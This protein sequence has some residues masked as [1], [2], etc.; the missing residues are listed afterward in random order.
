MPTRRRKSSP[1]L[2]ISAT[3]I[4]DASERLIAE[5]ST[6]NHTFEVDID[7]IAPDPA[8]A[9]RSF[10]E[11]SLAAL[12]TTLEAEGQLQ[13]VLLRRDPDNRAG[14]IIVAGE[15]RWR[16]AKLLN[17]PKL[18]AMAYTGDAEVAALVENLQRV[19]LSPVEEA[20]GIAR[21]IAEKGW[22]QDRAAQ[23][24]GKPKSDVSGTLR[25]L[26]L[27]PE[28]LDQVLTSEYVPAKNVLIELARISDPALLRQLASY[29]R[30]GTLTVKAIRTA[31]DDAPA[32]APPDRL[33][34]VPSPGRHWYTL[35]KAGAVARQLAMSS[36]PVPSSENA[37]LRDLRNAIDHLLG[38]TEADGT[39]A[40]EDL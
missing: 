11:R 5:G 38:S 20:R 17:W 23:A 35:R 21:L 8:Q 40:M 25:I 27:P 22:T 10:D 19:D 33:P 7:A 30:H 12:A 32:L 13:P 4:G 1:T 34:P 14:W 15:R 6:F 28:V 9:R 2:G 29:A 16:A 39:A 26:N 36:V 3:M 24:L 31:R 18:L 37:S